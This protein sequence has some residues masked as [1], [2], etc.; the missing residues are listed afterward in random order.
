VIETAREEAED[1]A[2]A[3]EEEIKE[4]CR[5]MASGGGRLV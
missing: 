3:L 2:N 5:Q 4:L 1:R